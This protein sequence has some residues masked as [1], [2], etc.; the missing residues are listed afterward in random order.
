MN[1]M[2]GQERKEKENRNEIEKRERK[3]HTTEMRRNE[4][5]NLWQ[6]NQQNP[7]DMTKKK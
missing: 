2:S 6:K 1:E 5:K 3:I 4:K 7:A